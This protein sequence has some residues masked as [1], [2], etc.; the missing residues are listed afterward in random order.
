MPNISPQISLLP[1]SIIIFLCITTS[2]TYMPPSIIVLWRYNEAALTQ[3][4]L[5]L[6]CFDLYL[7][8]VHC[9]Y[10]SF[11]PRV[12]LQGALSYEVLFLWFAYSYV[13]IPKDQHFMGLVPVHAL[14]Y[15]WVALIYLDKNIVFDAG[16][17]PNLSDSYTFYSIIKKILR[18]CNY[19]CSMMK[20]YWD[21]NDKTLIHYCH[22]I[23]QLWRNCL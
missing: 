4:F 13:R 20:K 17:A 16:R 14:L 11:V 10:V 12:W 2:C 23:S 19:N 5:F 3:P 21:N 6:Y 7:I 18:P 1:R 9:S 15:L 22:F 8:F